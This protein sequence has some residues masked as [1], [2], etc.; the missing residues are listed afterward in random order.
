MKKSKLPLTVGAVVA[1]AAV[2]TAAVVMWPDPESGADGAPK[3][4]P[5]ASVAVAKADLSDTQEFAGTLG[6]GTESTVKGPQTGVITWLPGS[7]STIGRGKPLFKIDARPVTLFYGDTPLYRT[8]DTPDARKSGG[9]ENKDDGKKDDGK[10]EEEKKEPEK[11]TSVLKGPDVRLVKDNLKALG[12]SA[13]S[14]DDYNT[15][16]AEAVK[17]WQK[18]LKLA[19][20]G[21]VQPG[22]VNVQPGEV[23]TAGI[24][25]QLGDTPAGAAVLTVTLTAKVVTVQVPAAQIGFIKNGVAAN[26]ILPDG[27]ETAGKVT[28]VS[29]TAVGGDKMSGGPAKLDVT[30]L[31][32]D[33]A[34]VG[35]LE[36]APVQVKFTTETRKG[37]LTVPIGALVAL[38]EGGYAVQ[39]KNGGLVAVQTGL[40][41]KGKVEVSGDGLQEGVEVVTTS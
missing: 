22:D 35:K 34:T 28:S 33:L 11:D 30:V 1:V 13:G 21:I 8:L 37:V 29:Q 14:G 26:V 24:G 25:A 41:S 31:L 2:A 39:I 6:Y 36:S 19:P 18:S 17:K 10:K 32:D 9:S 27:K 4:T 7:G 40:F 15:A 12:F 16:T 3:K 5:L 23:R 38:R 20:T